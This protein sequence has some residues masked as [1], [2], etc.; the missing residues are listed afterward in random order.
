M[1]KVVLASASPR[2]RELFRQICPVFSVLP[3]DVD[4]SLPPHVHPREAVVLLAKRKAQTVFDRVIYGM[5]I[6]DG[7]RLIVLGA[8]TVVALGMEI[9]GKP[10]DSGEACRM[11]RMLSGREHSVYTGVCF[12]TSGKAWADA[13][14]SRVMF[15]CLTDEQISD[16]VAG[17]S[18]M[19]K[20][21]AYGIQD[22]VA[23]AGYTG[24]Y[25]NIVGLPVELT[26]K[27]YGEV[28]RY[29]KDSY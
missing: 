14:E 11:L 20:A 21:G 7:E 5:G 2:R 10:K 27:M 22:G 25:S 3:A 23:V 6:S 13:E 24:S 15:N 12:W 4:E 8:D 1:L 9:L 26:E 28:L 18:P 16:Y 19:D 29:D 17:G